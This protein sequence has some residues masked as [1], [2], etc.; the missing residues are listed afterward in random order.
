MRKRS[1][2]SSKTIAKVIFVFLIAVIFALCIAI[3]Q[4]NQN[5]SDTE[6]AGNTSYV[7]EYSSNDYI[8]EDMVELCDYSELQ[9][10]IDIP[11]MITDEDLEKYVNYVLL[12]I[13]NMNC[14]I[15]L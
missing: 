15:K 6:S 9:V 8:L 3:L 1:K 2:E 7:S 10:T 5:K 4:L 12:D 14:W 11:E 13:L